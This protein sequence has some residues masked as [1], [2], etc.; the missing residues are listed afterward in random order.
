[1]I[2]ES[3]MGITNRFRA[4]IQSFRKTDNS[5]DDQLALAR[6]FLRY[7]NKD[8][9]PLVQNWS[10]VIMT[11]RDLY[12]GYSYSAIH[13]RAS[14]IAMLATNNIMTRANDPI[15]KAAREKKETLEHPYLGIIDKSKS[16]ANWK[17]WYDISTYIDLEGVY[18]LMAVR[19][20]DENRVGI[21]QSFKMLNPYEIQ[22]VRNQDTMEIGGYIERRDGRFREIPPEMIIEVRML[23]PFDRDEPYAMT[24]AIKDS[25]FTL[26]SASDYTRHSIVNN[27]NAP[28][29]ISTDVIIPAEEFKNFKS[30]VVNHEKGEPLFGNG[31]GA[32]NW[33]DMQIDLNKAALD[34]VHDIS[35]TSVIAGSGMSKTM[36]GIEQSGVTRET[37]KVQ[38]ELFYTNHGI[39]QLQFIIDGLNQDYKNYYEKEYARTGYTIYIDSPLGADLDAEIKEVRVRKDS[40]AVYSTL[41]NKGYNHDIASKY[42]AGEIT[43]AEI[44]EPTEESVATAITSNVT[45]ETPASDTTTQ[46]T[47]STTANH[48]EHIDAIKNQFDDQTQG[49]ITNQQGALQNVVVGIEAR[50]ATAVLNK[51]TKNQFETQSDIIADD[52]KEAFTTE[53]E[54]ALAAF[55]GII[56]PLYAKTTLSRRVAEFGL[57]ADFKLNTE[58]KSYIKSVAKKA[59]ES[60]INTIL[61]DLLSTIQK[62]YEQQVAKTFKV[63]SEAEASK[64]PEAD[65][66]SFLKS[67][68]AKGKDS[69]IYRLAQKKALEGSGQQEII[70]AI[71]KEYND[72]ANNRA[73]TIART[74]TARAF[75]SSQYQADKQF[76]QQ[77]D[78]QGKAYKKWVTRSSNPCPLCLS[79][80]AQ[81]PIPFDTPFANI[82]DEVSAT[83]E[84][85]GKTKVLK[86]KVTYET[87]EAG[88]LHVNCSCIYQLIIETG[89][90]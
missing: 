90:I 66:E 25:Q 26:K 74:E 12:T 37:A 20:V 49:I 11:D 38:R 23:N 52:D 63:L 70:S 78:L 86:Q 6:R 5:L 19:A 72:I 21:I 53:L 47:D 61:E 34:K 87:I 32:M 54:I 8:N 24:D 69:D 85:D 27:V 51:V 3:S 9:K 22:R 17:F 55:Y 45:A 2:R 88:N 28:G 29:M 76:I 57:F 10:Q 65:R 73:K 31:G 80:A 60:H 64:L 1:M 36:L 39:P 4:A 75:T 13:N 62:T 7:G 33:N 15:M 18:Y 40:Y 81:G 42:A 59:S 58:V 68:T 83:Y 89:G 84:Q 77:N 16:F 67:L 46:T 41:R 43:I 79:K 82:G 44:G 50:V 35:L 71:K 48:H 56:L 30:R 14:A